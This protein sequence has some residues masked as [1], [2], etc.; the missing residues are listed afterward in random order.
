MT[1][2]TVLTS[3][4]AADRPP[5]ERG[6]GAG[7]SYPASHRPRMGLATAHGRRWVQH[8]LGTG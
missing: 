8:D 7:L 2:E 1:I 5:T 6:S 4:A 3:I